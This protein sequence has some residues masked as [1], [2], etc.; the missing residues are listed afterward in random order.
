MRNIFNVI[1]FCTPK[2]PPSWTRSQTPRTWAWVSWRGMG[3]RSRRPWSCPC[4]AIVI[5]IDARLHCHFKKGKSSQICSMKNF[6]RAQGV[7]FL[8][9]C[10]SCVK[11]LFQLGLPALVLDLR[12]VMRSRCSFS[13][14]RS[15][16]S[17][18]PT[19]FMSVL[20]RADVMYLLIRSHVVKYLNGMI[21]R[22]L[23]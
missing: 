20:C 7:W 15:R 23:H 11:T 1:W 9:C 6:T 22:I 10:L 12:P 14:I 4:S 8:A 16:A 17:W 18:S 13:C 5:I 2:R 21:L 3:C 19:A